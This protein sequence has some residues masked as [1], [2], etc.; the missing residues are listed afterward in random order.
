MG[1]VKT[2]QQVYCNAFLCLGNTEHIYVYVKK[3]PKDQKL[4]TQ[5]H[6]SEGFNKHLNTFTTQKGTLYSAL[7]GFQ[8]AELSG[9]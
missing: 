7:N 2:L 3:D 1:Q 8:K 4:L 9:G 6:I 5:R